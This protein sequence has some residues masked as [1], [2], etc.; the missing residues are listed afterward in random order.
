MALTPPGVFVPLDVN[1]PRDLRIRRAG[2]D[3]ELL[4]VR[5]NA[6]AKNAKTDGVIYDFDLS[7]VAVGLTRVQ[8]RV[9]ALV[10]EGLWIERDDGWE[11]RSWSKWN[12]T[13]AELEELKEHKRDAG[14]LGN[15]RRWHKDKPDPSCRLCTPQNGR[16]TDRTTDR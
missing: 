3:A 14:A 5:G 12:A 15:H 11:I 13:N 1:Y 4:W 10:R 7:V 6:H 9:K 2:P 8:Q 16:R